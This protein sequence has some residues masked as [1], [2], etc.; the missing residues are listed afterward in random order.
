MDKQY[1]NTELRMLEEGPQMNIHPDELEAVPFVRYSGPFLKWTR[2]ELR[3][4]DQKTRK[5]MTMHKALH[6]EEREEEDFP[7]L[8]TAWTHPYNDPKQRKT[9]Y[10]HQKQY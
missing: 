6:Q 3:Q 5:L 10:S 8:K 1:G 2:E 4:M 7:A 9:D